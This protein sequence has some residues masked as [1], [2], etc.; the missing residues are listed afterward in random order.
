MGDHVGIK[1][2]PE[3]ITESCHNCKGEDFISSLLTDFP[4]PAEL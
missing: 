1:R 2:D 4:S 3:G